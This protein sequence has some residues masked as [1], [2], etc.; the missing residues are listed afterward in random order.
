MLTRLHVNSRIDPGFLARELNFLR[1]ALFARR[2][3]CARNVLLR[4]ALLYWGS[5]LNKLRADKRRVCSKQTQDASEEQ[6][7]LQDR[8][9]HIAGQSV[10][11]SR[12]DST[13]YRCTRKR[14]ALHLPDQ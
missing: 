13:V 9:K 7:I 6:A 3:L 4:R 5:L 12:S 1:D 2:S 11:Q 10:K 8:A 14:Q